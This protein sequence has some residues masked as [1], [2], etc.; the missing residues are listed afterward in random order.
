MMAVYSATCSPL[1]YELGCAPG[2]GLPT[3]I[4]SPLYK[5]LAFRFFSLFYTQIATFDTLT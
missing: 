5:S 4:A 1:Q 3:D 2:M